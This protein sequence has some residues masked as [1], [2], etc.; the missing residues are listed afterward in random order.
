VPGSGNSSTTIVNAKDLKIPCNPF[1]ENFKFNLGQV[2]NFLRTPFGRAQQVATTAA[3]SI[4][5]RGAVAES[6]GMRSLFTVISDELAVGGVGGL[7]EGGLVDAVFEG[8]LVW[9]VTGAAVTSSF[10]AGFIGGVAIGSGIEAAMGN[11]PCA[12]FGPA[13]GGG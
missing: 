7:L 11:S 9:G 4:A 3:M 8:G 12:M 10:A 2:R 1:I 6:L 5:A 13:A